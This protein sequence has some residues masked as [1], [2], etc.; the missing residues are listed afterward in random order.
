[1]E[2]LG[3][4]PRRA[5]LDSVGCAGRSPKPYRE[6]SNPSSFAITHSSNGKTAGS[7]PV[8]RGSNP[9]WVALEGGAQ[10]C[11]T[12]LENQAMVTM[13]VRLLHSP[14]WK[15]CGVG[16]APAA[17]GGQSSAGGS[18]PPPSAGWVLGHKGGCNPLASASSVRFRD[19]QP[20]GP[21]P[22]GE[23]AAC[24]AAGS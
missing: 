8:N 9:W 11:A 13:R 14:L 15:V 7:G 3:S 21:D 12:G 17:N 19:V 2:D 20:R 1:P 16:R 24:K 18:T 5:I 23:D 6:G 10:W 4:N 22:L